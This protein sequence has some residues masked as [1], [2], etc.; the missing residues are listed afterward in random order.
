[1]LSFKS[2]LPLR[3]ESKMKMAKL[4]PLKVYPF[5]LNIWIQCPVYSSYL[6]WLFSKKTL[7]YC[8]SPVGG[9]V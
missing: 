7:R 9:G 6:A 2:R 8:H 4:F 1:M 5:S 3:R